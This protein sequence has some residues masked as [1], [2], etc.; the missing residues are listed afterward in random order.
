MPHCK[1]PSKWALETTK[2]CINKE[3]VG[4]VDGIEISSDIWQDSKCSALLLAFGEPNS[5]T[6]FNDFVLL[7]KKIVTKKTHYSE[8]VEWSLG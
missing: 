5:I 4:T 3:N 1:L 8:D 7:C 2:N 6:I